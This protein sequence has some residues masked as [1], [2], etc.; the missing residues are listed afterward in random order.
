[1][2]IFAID[3][4][5]NVLE[6][7]AATIAEALPGATIRTYSRGMAA[8]DEIRRGARP[9]WVFSDIEIPGMAG[10]EL[11]VRI[12]E[13][14]PESRIVFTTGY[15]KYAV[16]AFRIKAQGYLIKPVSVED[17]R[18]ELEYSPAKDNSYQ[19]KLVVRCFGYFDVFW[20]GEPL[21]FAR[22]QS[23]EMLAYLIDREGAACTAGELASILWQ[24][25]C[26]VQTEQNRIRVLI[27]DLRNTLRKI[28]MEDVL[29]RKHREIAIRR[30]LMDCDYYRMQDGDMD[31]VNEYRGQYM[32]QYSWAEIKNARLSFNF[33]K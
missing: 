14:A 1:M 30:D 2:L 17:I 20:H 32:A 23:K 28:G 27:N 9:D 21:F 5:E 7:T 24:D 10:L 13:E 12:K 11:A 15:E 31:A 3:D 19:D 4:E 25:P 29:I 33:P 16:E 26:D 8:L 18:R 22:K 6:E